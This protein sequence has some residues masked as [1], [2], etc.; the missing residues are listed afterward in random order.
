MMDFPKLHSEEKLSFP[1]L[2]ALVFLSYFI[3]LVLPLFCPGLSV[4]ASTFN[5]KEKVNY[6][7]MESF[8]EDNS[9]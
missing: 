1:P 3:L 5:L 4:K 8:L 2:F 9:P 7:L 6:G